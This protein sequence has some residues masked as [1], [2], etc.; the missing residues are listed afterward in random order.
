MLIMDESFP[1]KGYKSDTI[2][3]DAT[4]RFEPTLYIS[5]QFAGF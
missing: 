1:A 4:F 3:N 5:Q 2:I